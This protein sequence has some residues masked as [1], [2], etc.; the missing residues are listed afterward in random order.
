[1]S[2]LNRLFVPSL[3]LA[4]V[5]FAAAPVLIHNAPYETTMGLV[6]KIFYFHVPAAMMMFVSAFVCGIASGRYLFA[7]KPA[8]DRV[9]VAAAELVVLFGVIVLVTGPIWA[10]KAW[11]VWWQ[12]EARLTSTL[13]LFMIFLAYLLLRRYGGPG[14]DRL[15]A[16]LALFGMA[17]V[18]FVYW[19]VNVWR[20]LHPKTSVVMT[21]DPAMRPAFWWCV[22]A[23]VLLYLALLAARTRLEEQRSRLEGLYLA[24]DD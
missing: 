3:G 23:F 20:T 8:A 15:G 1:M 21:L 6:Q 19:S 7:R 11:G 14:S 22:T 5:M 12:W 9:A 17:N 4:L 13:V 24:L 16:G 2:M 10:R 18:P